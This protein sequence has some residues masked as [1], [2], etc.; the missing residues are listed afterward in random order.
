[1]NRSQQEKQEHLHI[2]LVGTSA[3]ANYAKDHPGR[4]LSRRELA[5]WLGDKPS[6]RSAELNGLLPFI[7]KGQCTD[8]HLVTTDTPDAR[9]CRDA[10]ADYLS[11]VHRVRLTGKGAEAGGLLPASFGQPCRPEDFHAG[12][13]RLREFIFRAARGARNRGA[14]VMIN[15]TGGLKAMA[16]VAALVAAELSVPAYYMHESM[17]EPVFL[18]T[19]ALDREAL[20]RLRR[21]ESVH[22]RAALGR[23]APNELLRFEREGLVKVSRK[24][25]GEMSNVKLTAYGKHLA[26]RRG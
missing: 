14:E 1:M 21:L 8:A 24:P 4:R 18:P 11:G 2:I 26:K 7:R 13:C 22:G 9:L 16:A 23:L 15:A 3:L 10:L 5:A 19:V 25:D 12:A 20:G 6:A 17:E